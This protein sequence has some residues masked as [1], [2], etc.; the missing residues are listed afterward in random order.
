MTNFPI[1]IIVNILYSLSIYQLIATSFNLVYHTTKFFNLS[2][3]AILSLAAYL[4]YLNFIVFNLNLYISILIAIFCS[5]ILS[6]ICEFVIYRYMRNKNLL[7]F[8]QLIASI[9]VYTILENIISL[10][11]GND[12]KSIRIGEVKVGHYFLGAYISDIQVI[13]ITVSLMIFVSILLLLHKTSLGRQIRAVSSNPELSNIYGIMS[14]KIILGATAISSSLAAVVGILISLD[15][16][17]TPAFGMNYFLYGVI[18]SIIGGVGRYK[19]LFW[20]SLL[21]ASAQHLAGY[22]LDTK[23]MDAVAYV[24][25]IVFLIIKPLGFS[26]QHLKKV[27]V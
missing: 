27:R 13:T 12:T 14:N 6:V 19:G 8:T 1:Q 15:V 21:L 17:M 22:Y 26:G 5:V 25:L 20:G 18:A 10:S 16:D 4:T 11:F 2:L 3:A 23:W 9:G 7:P 24:I